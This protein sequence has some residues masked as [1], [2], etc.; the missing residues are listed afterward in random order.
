MLNSSVTP[1]KSRLHY[2]LTSIVSL[3]FAI[4]WFL[5][6]PTPILAEKSVNSVSGTLTAC[7]IND[8]TT[9]HQNTQTIIVRIDDIPYAVD[10]SYMKQAYNSAEE[11]YSTLLSLKGC[12]VDIKYINLRFSKEG[13]IILDLNS[14]GS[15]YVTYNTVYKTLHEKAC[16]DLLICGICVVISLI[17]IYKALNMRSK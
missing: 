14:N 13:R 9:P 5:Y 8:V 10:Y 7:S 4:I 2:L 1:R 3:L 15:N 6:S 16:R 11:M 12:D 17:S